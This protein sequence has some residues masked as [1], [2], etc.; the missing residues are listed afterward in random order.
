[1]NFSYRLNT[2]HFRESTA[3]VSCCRWARNEYHRDCADLLIISKQSSTQECKNA[4]M[5]SCWFFLSS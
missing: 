4:A 2:F 3:A 5:R 1:M